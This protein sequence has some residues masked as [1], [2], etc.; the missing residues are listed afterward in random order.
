LSI[1]A[2]CAD[3]WLTLVGWGVQQGS[4]LRRQALAGLGDVR[5]APVG[6]AGRSRVRWIGALAE[7][8]AGVLV[9]G[10]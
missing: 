9:D 1:P 4:S 2:S 8:F 10:R 6:C 5:Q 7:F 3:K